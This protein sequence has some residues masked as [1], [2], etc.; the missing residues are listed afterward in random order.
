M[1]GV[2]HYGHIYATVNMEFYNKRRVDNACGWIISVMQYTLCG[3][4]NC[5]HNVWRHTCMLILSNIPHISLNHAESS[6][7]CV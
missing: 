6:N 1:Y 5:N 7:G 4:L 2:C 3:K